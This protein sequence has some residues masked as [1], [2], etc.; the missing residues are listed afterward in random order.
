MRTTRCL[1][2]LLSHCGRLGDR[3]RV[4]TIAG[5]GHYPQITHPQQLVDAIEH[6]ATARA[7]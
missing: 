5:A 6:A 1:P 3:L 4:T 2:M 7:R